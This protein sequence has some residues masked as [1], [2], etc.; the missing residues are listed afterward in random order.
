MI[1]DHEDQE[2][3]VWATPDQ[4]GHSERRKFVRLN[5]PS[6]LFP[7]TPNVAKGVPWTS[8]SGVKTQGVQQAPRGTACSEWTIMIEETL[9]FGTHYATSVS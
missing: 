3:N 5:G 2:V 1:V 9:G 8:R 4:G 7:T 6:V